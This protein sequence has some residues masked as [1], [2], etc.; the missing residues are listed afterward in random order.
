MA[1]GGVDLS[2]RSTQLLGRFH[3]TKGNGKH[4]FQQFDHERTI[5]MELGPFRHILALANRSNCGVNHTSLAISLSSNGHHFNVRQSVGCNVEQTHNAQKRS[6]HQFLIKDILDN[7]ECLGNVAPLGQLVAKRFFDFA[8]VHASTGHKLQFVLLS[9]CKGILCL[10]GILHFW[11]FTSSVDAELMSP[12]LQQLLQERC[13][14]PKTERGLFQEQSHV[15]AT[16]V[17]FILQFLV[18][19]TIPIGELEL[20][21][22]FA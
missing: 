20:F 17:Q 1:V 4:L 21:T 9:C 13:R 12:M 22:C 15:N 8:K 6:P 7:R 14:I 10:I 11:G 2:H 18:T 3:I 5:T 16:N 19:H